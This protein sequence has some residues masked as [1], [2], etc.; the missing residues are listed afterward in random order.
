MIKNIEL[1]EE[2]TVI[3]FNENNIDPYFYLSN[4]YC[5]IALLISR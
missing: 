5:W 1:S 3:N 2:T 4:K